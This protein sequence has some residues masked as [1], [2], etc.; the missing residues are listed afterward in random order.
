MYSVFVHITHTRIRLQQ[1]ITGNCDIGLAM[2]AVCHLL[3]KRS[4]YDASFMLHVNW[5]QILAVWQLSTSL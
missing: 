3:N 5:R 2:V 4:S 1:P